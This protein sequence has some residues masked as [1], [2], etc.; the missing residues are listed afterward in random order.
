MLEGSHLK[1]KR[2]IR[3]KIVSIL[4][5]I[6]TLNSCTTHQAIDPSKQIVHSNDG[7][8]PGETMS[9]EKIIDKIT[10]VRIGITT[11]G[12]NYKI[13]DNFN[14]S[15]GPEGASWEV[16]C[17][18]DLISDFT[19][20][21]ISNLYNRSISIYYDS[22]PAPQR[23]CIDGH[24]FPGRIAAIRAGKNKPHQT[25]TDGCIPARHLSELLNANEIAIRF[26][27]WPYDENIDKLVSLLGLSD[28]IELVKF[29][30]PFGSPQN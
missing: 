11:S 6:Q 26:V 24:D 29:I 18:N 19:K 10:T 30:R 1:K 22:S 8:F 21:E 9:K 16:T 15:V 3:S 17:K 23:I 25:N 27:A 2:N 4:L 7:W 5:I 13:Y 28:A 12:Y 14:G 20:C